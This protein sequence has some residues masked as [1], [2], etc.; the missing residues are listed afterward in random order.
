M[1]RGRISL[2]REVE[3]WVGQA[4]ALPRTSEV[5]IDAAV[6]SMAGLL[7]DAFPGDPGTA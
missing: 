6:A 4:L 3:Q 2:D 1:R 7:P 5:A